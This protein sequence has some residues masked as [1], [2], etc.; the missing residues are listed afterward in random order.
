MVSKQPRKQRRAIYKAPLHRR[1][2]LVRAHLSETL[3]ERY[4]RRSVGIRKGD[5]VEIVRG[6]FAGHKGRVEAVSLKRL[7]IH[8]SGASVK[9]TDGTDRYYPI[10]PSNVVV[11]KLDTGDERRMRKLKGGRK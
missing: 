4:G 10:H 8:V 1:Q 11:T 9:R 3:R 6:D 5:T 7:R 2:R